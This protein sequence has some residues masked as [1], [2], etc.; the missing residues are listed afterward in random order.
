[1]RDLGAEPCL[2][3]LLLKGGQQAQR[4]GP[5]GDDAHSTRPTRRQQVGT[6]IG[7]GV[8]LASPISWATAK[9]PRCVHPRMGPFSARLPGIP[10]A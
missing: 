2:H 10:G 7:A 3:P 5:Q 1:M 4:P 8:A 6:L 9:P